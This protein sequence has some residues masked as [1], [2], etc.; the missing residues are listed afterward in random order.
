MPIN[1]E[2]LLAEFLKSFKIAVNGALLY[3]KS[4]P[5]FMRYIEDLKRKIDPLFDFLNP[6]K[7]V[8]TPNSLVIDDK[9]F[10]KTSWYDEL[11]KILHRRKIK[12]IEFKRGITGQELVVLLDRISLP[13]LEILKQGGVDRIFSRNDN[14]HF[15]IE[16]LDYS[17]LLIDKEGEGFNEAWFSLVESSINHNET[18]KINE[19]ADNFQIIVAKIKINDLVTDE[20][21]RKSMSDFMNYLKVNQKE[22]FNKCCQEL[23]ESALKYRGELDEAQLLSLQSFFIGLDE[24]DLANVL[25]NK[26]SLDDDFGPVGLRLFSQ[27]A[28][29]DKHKT[30]VSTVFDKA[31]DISPASGASRIKEKIEKLFSASDNIHIPEIY[32]N[33]LSALRENSS[34][35]DKIAFDRDQVDR[36]YRFIL[37]NLIIEEKDDGALSMLLEKVMEDWD[38]IIANRDFEYL[39]NLIEV[40][41]RKTSE[42]PDCRR[43]FKK[44]DDRIGSFLEAAVFEQPFNQSIKPLIESIEKSSAGYD[45]YLEKIFNDKKVNQQALSLFFRLFPGDLERFRNKLEQN[46]ADIDLLVNMI[47]DLKHVDSLVS[48]DVLKY[49]FYSCNEYIKIEALRAMQECSNFDK[50]FLFSIITRE[51]NALKKEAL[52]VIMRDQEMLKEALQMLFDI[53]NSFGRSNGVIIERISLVEEIE[54]KE[55]SAFLAGFSRKMF[56]WNR[57]LRLKAREVLR[58]WNAE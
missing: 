35:E 1:K 56:F 36:N 10:S 39:K 33:M 6:L 15:T 9:T 4:H 43:I 2:E 7:V 49:L 54:L 52:Q 13:P 30:I 25:W 31:R 42:N 47:E 55:A 34:L 5:F 17:S 27:L 11:V 46:R 20:R 28:G 24:K 53:P 8:I 51:N 37:L 45:F 3:T 57:A 38:T 44:I 18:R 48:L 26:L 21:L 14:T 40:S 50:E 32:Q 12:S 22:K 29:K 19:F 16:E 41:R 58:K 23:L